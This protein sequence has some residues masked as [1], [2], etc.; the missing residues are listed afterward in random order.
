MQFLF[1]E[2]TGRNRKHMQQDPFIKR[3][4][5]TLLDN[6]R[7]FAMINM[8][9]FHGTWDLVYVY[10][11]DWDWYKG[12]GAYIWQQSICWTF[13]LLSGFCWSLGRKRLKRGWMVFCAG[14]LVTIATLIFMWE[15][16]VIFGI[17]TLLG[18]CMLFMVPMDKFLKKIPPELGAVICFGLFVITRNCNRGYLG[19]EGWKLAEL[20]EEL[21]QGMFATYIG[22]LAPDFYS[23]D[24]FSLLPWMFLFVSGYFIYHIFEKRKWT[25]KFL[26]MKRLPVA[27]YMGRH[28]LVI[29]LIHQPILY[30]LCTV[31]N[32]VWENIT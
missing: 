10:G 17:L 26:E 28:S 24:Y 2:M 12:V 9:L 30:L 21:Y 13:I 31:G 22:F 5:Y 18:S 14:A 8:I 32:M 1:E 23:T 29:Y 27:N 19:F 15:N 7:G 3:T 16:R 6:I 11:V 25:S 20:P 4:R